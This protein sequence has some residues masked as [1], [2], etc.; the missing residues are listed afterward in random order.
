MN[1]RSREPE[2]GSTLATGCPEGGGDPGM[3]GTGLE[4]AARVQTSSAHALVVDDECDW[5]ELLRARLERLG[6]SVEEAPDGR[7]A[8]SLV[9]QGEFDVC[10]LDVRMPGEDGVET[11]GHLRKRAPH[12]RI[13]LVTAL[14]DER[15]F[16]WA[17]S[18]GPSPD[19]FLQKPVSADALARCLDIVVRRSGRYLR[20][21]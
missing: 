1:P 6:C 18:D 17:D 7:T 19:G 21:Y 8:L 2:P 9:S 12:M 5:R 20:M 4:V 10:F 16:S 15:S 14:P 3:G 11:L 13:V